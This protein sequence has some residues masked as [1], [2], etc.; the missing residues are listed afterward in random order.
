MEF[1]ALISPLFSAGF[2]LSELSVAFICG[3]LFG[4][5]SC[6]S[7]HLV[8]ICCNKVRWGLHV[9]LSMRL[10]QRPKLR[11]T[12]WFKSYPYFSC[13]REERA[14]ADI[15]IFKNSLLFLKSINSGFPTFSA[16]A[17]VKAQTPEPDL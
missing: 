17:S 13:L 15:K 1:W 8:C 14:L 16:L 2:D 11:R 3:I 9:S 7:G 5:V 12:S 6:S 4:A 10:D